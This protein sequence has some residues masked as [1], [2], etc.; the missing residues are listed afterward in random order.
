M[1]VHPTASHDAESPFVRTVLS[2]LERTEY[3]FCE[4]G[5]DLEAIYRLRYDSYLSAGMVRED[6]ARMVTDQFDDLPNA[7][8]YGI[9]YDGILV[10]TIRLH[11]VDASMPVSPSSEVFDDVLAPRIKAGESFVD[12]SRFAAAAEWS[13]TL[14]VLPYV[15]LRLAVLACK[16]FTPTYCLT[17]I[18][19]EH[20]AFYQR[21]FRSVPATDARNYP[22]LTVPVHL[23][24]SKC[25]ENME[26]TIERF[27]FFRSTAFERRM[28]F[29]RPKNGELAPLTILPT[30]KYQKRAA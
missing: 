30:A 2:V 9:Y 11:Y 22:G 13:R 7:F 26:N 3:R 4:S 18:K 1:S 16:Y 6:A 12:P 27:P 28:L 17:A 24:Q 5:E 8:R 21:I 25:S 20:S 29:E 14:R 15:T 19:E 10:S 23:L